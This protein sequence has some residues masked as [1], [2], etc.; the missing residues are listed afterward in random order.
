[1]ATSKP[2]KLGK[3]EVLDIVG[4]GSVGVVYKAIDPG[5]GRVVAI[6]MM[7]VGFADYPK[8]LK[9]FYREAQ[10]AGKLQ[11]PNI[12]TIYDLG[13]QDGNPYLVMEF[14]KGEDLGSI[15]SA[16]RPISLEQKLNIVIQICNA[17]GYAHPR[18]VVHRSI[19]PANTIVLQD[20]TVKIVDFG[21]ARIGNEKATRPG[22][23][24]GSIQYMAPEQ[25]NAS[26]VDSRTDIFSV[27]VLL[28][29]LLAHALPFDGKDTGAILLKII[30]DPPTPL[31]TY[32]RAYPADLD[33]ILA[34]ALAK[35]REDR[36]ATAD[37]LAFDLAR[38]QEELKRNK[39]SAYLKS[40]DGLMANSQWKQAKEQ[41]LEVLKIDQQNTHVNDLLRTIQQRIQA[42]HRSEQARE[43]RLQAEQAI[44]R[45]ELR[46]ALEY[47]DRAVALDTDGKD[48]LQVRNLVAE[49]KARAEQFAALLQRAES[50][51]DSGD[52]EDAQKAITEALALE[53]DN[54]EATE[55]NAIITHEITE[56]NKLTQ[57]QKYLDEARRRLASR[58]FTDA[59]DMLKKAEMLSPNAPGVKELENLAVSGQ[60]QEKRRKQIEQFNAEIEDALN[61]D[62]FALAC[63]KAME[64][65]RLFPEERSLLK[66]KGLAEK[67]REASEKRAYVEGQ[68][69]A[70]HRLLNS[71][72]PDQSLPLLKEAL[73]KYPQETALLSMLSVVK[74]TLNRLR[75]ERNKAEYGKRAK[76]AIR[77]KAY[78]EAIQI[79][80]EGRKEIVSSELDDLLQFAQEEASNYATRKKIDGVVDQSHQLI[81]AH[82]YQ[83]AIDLLESV[84][85]ELNDEDL[86]I[87]LA[88]ARRHLEEFNQ[89]INEAIA[90]AERL[91]RHDRYGEAVR[92]LEGRCE[93][94]G[95]CPELAAF[96]QQAR[97]ELAR[98]QKF[99]VTK[100][101]VREA[102]ALDDFD[103][104]STTLRGFREQFGETLDA[105]LLQQEIETARSRVATAAMEKALGDARVLLMVRS[106]ESVEGI[107]DSVA[108]W[109]NYA[110]PELRERYEALKALALESRAKHAASGWAQRLNQARMAEQVTIS[111]VERNE[112]GT[113]VDSETNSTAAMGRTQ[114]EAILGQVTQIAGH[115]ADNQRVQSAI[116]ALKQRLTISIAALAEEEVSADMPNV[117]TSGSRET[118]TI[119]RSRR[120]DGTSIPPE[121]GR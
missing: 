92:F 115:Y 42:Q 66:H 117:N 10:S 98:V 102:I 81:S 105:R 49:R 94:C 28:Y 25:I 58:S 88:D 45:N 114:L 36:Y 96:L 3:Y 61:R 83:R 107:L 19:K 33:N 24:T 15:I 62:E 71:A 30:H 104:A 31:S 32:L 99:S 60:E 52:L 78:E 34:R 57:F 26:E 109:R 101:N 91:L 2:K 73:K 110:T 95:E 51:R 23:I 77:R 84:L 39:V 53:K 50:A 6:K 76:D 89:Q 112:D 14:L 54:R 40:V 22:Q 86:I 17:L 56:Q 64:G 70:A 63:S 38:V 121:P 116:D 75:V 67:Q 21:I 27:G 82:E 90:K 4:R 97:Y 16:R 118:G 65:L 47:L 37:D 13:D 5:I 74:E 68:I 119:R 35:T 20:F 11:H 1:M 46:D 113:A 120:R 43:F 18:G 79:L 80:N 9:R 48:L 103:G 7:T 72:D 29:Q 93:Q 85:K 108:K 12:V 55:L 87:I 69:A 111:R 59:L 106:V 100:E 8:L 44:A 41:I